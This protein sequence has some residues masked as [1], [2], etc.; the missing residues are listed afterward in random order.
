LFITN[1]II[2]KTAKNKF[3][4]FG[5]IKC[6]KSIADKTINV[7]KIKIQIKERITNIEI[8]PGINNKGSDAAQYIGTKIKIKA[9]NNS[10]KKY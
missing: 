10:T 6:F 7:K 8:C 2:P 5:I 4:E 1:K 3:T 9:D